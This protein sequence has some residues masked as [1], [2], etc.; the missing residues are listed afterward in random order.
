MFWSKPS[1]RVLFVCTENI[2]RSPMAEA[3]LRQRLHGLG[4]SRKVGVDSA[5]THVSRRGQRPDAR[6]EQVCAATACNLS[7]IRSRQVS[8][9][10]LV[11]YD[12][13]LAMEQSHLDFLLTLCP[14][15]FEHKLKLV[16]AYGPALGVE[17]VP[18]PYFGNRQSFERVHTMLSSALDGLA[19]KLLTLG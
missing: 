3:L 15:N 1:Y 16:M 17:E 18:D 10:D 13:V 12:L 4:L 5:G 6:V 2:C 19:E 11:R 7:G 14:D 9:R 8:Q